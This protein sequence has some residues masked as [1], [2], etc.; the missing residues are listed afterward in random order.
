MGPALDTK[1]SSTEPGSSAKASAAAAF[2]T[3]W[4][5]AIVPQALP[6]LSCCCMKNTDSGTPLPYAPPAALALA[7]SSARRGRLT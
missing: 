2:A 6:I 4:M 1:A 5:E 7:L 3:A